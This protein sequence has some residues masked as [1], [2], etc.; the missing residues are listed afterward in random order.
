[1]AIKPKHK[2]VNMQTVTLTLSGLSPET[3]KSILAGL[4]STDGEASGNTHTS[5]SNAKSA[6]K[7]GKVSKKAA[8]VEDEADEEIEEE[9]EGADADVSDEV[10]EEAQD[11]TVP[12][13]QKL[14]AK[15]AQEKDA[16]T[17]KKLLAKYKV[18][19]VAELKQ[20]KLN[21]LAEEI[22]GLLE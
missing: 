13:V 10:E 16:G 17:A 12:Q 7:A 3:A 15:L 19:K 18:K 1:M 5:Q 22:N 4:A 20:V 6:T 21:Q 2:G 8:P 11:F 9:Y 14:M